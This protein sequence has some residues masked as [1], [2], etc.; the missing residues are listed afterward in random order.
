MLH[1]RPITCNVCIMLPKVQFDEY[2]A[3][4]SQNLPLAIRP[5]FWF[6]NLC[7]M[8]KKGCVAGASK[9]ILSVA[10]GKDRIS[11]PSDVDFSDFR[12]INF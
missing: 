9:K 4:L 3:T 10:A 1:L 2:S 6:H 11:F 12:V 7:N 8:K 5:T